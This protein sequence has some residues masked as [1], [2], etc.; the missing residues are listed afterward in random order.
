M[1]LKVEIETQTFVRF[2]LVVIAFT[3]V[4]SSLYIVRGALV[5]IGVALFLA[6]ALN[7][8][9]TALASKLP[10]KSRIGATALAYLIVVTIVGGILFL[11]IPPI[12]QQTMKFTS[13]V[14]SLIDRATSQR[15]ALDDFIDSNNLRNVVDQAVVN[16]KKQATD[17]STQLG[18]LF[19]SAITGAFGWTVNLIFV[20]VLGF[21]MLVEGPSWMSKIWSLYND[22]VKRDAHRLSV[23]KMYRVVTGFVIGQISVAT[24][25]A[26]FVFLTI[27]VMSLFPD[28]HVPINIAL[29][30]AVIVF[31]LEIIPM[32]GAPLA[33]IVVGLILMFNSLA[34]GLLFAIIYVIYQQFEN[35]LIAPH[36]QSKNVE[37]SVLWIL[38][39]LLIGTSLFGIIGGLIAIPVAGSLRILL[40]DYVEYSK[41]QYRENKSKGIAK[42]AKKLSGKDA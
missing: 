36:I 11:V 21:F 32:V 34:A 42:L 15:P 3:A 27:V 33:T 35:N 1:K 9:V 5:T 2:W 25:G 40:I 28:L 30:L 41:K 14:P 23:E 38:V 13:T 26:T 29:P 7:P 31:T 16:V 19:M 4:I 22:P 20:L 24:V 37:L 39:A 12:A 18:T 8:P 10:S 17:A 6:L